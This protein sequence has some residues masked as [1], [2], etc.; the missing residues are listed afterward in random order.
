MGRLFRECGVTGVIREP[1]DEVSSRNTA[2][3]TSSCDGAGRRARL[4]AGFT[5]IELMVTMAIVAILAAIAYPSYIQYV[6]RGNRAAAE[7]FLLEVSTLQERF[8]VD[9]RAYAPSLATLGYT[10]VPSTVSSAYQITVNVVPGPP[11]S[12]VLTATPAGS[13]AANDTACGT[14]TLSATGDKT[15]S[16]GG[17][18]CWK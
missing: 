7:S 6:V 5:L 4:D 3:T 1:A 10:S 9:N 18:G 11:P 17:T 14:L 8:L 13:Q 15:A 2:V 12:Y 16:G